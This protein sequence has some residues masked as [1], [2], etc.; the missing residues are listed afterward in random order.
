MV[1][2]KT[3]RKDRTYV[4]MLPE[5]DKTEINGLVRAAY[6]EIPRAGKTTA[7]TLDGA[8]SQHI[9]K[10]NRQYGGLIIYL[11]SKNGGLEQFAFQFPEK[12]FYENGE[13][14][15]R[16]DERLV[17]PYF[18]ALEFASREGLGKPEQRHIDMAFDLVGR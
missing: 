6:L 18:L 11:L 4:V 15:T 17:T 14:V 2:R 1:G 16:K 7:T 3:G 13:A 10:H 9:M 12:Y 5:A 8:V